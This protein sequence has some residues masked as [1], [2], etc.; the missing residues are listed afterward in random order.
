MKWSTRVAKA[1]KHRRGRFTRQEVALASTWTS[2]AIGELRQ[3][4]K[5]CKLPDDPEWLSEAD[6]LGMAFCLA[7]RSDDPVGAKAVLDQIK[8]MG[9]RT[10]ADL[11]RAWGIDVKPRRAAGRRD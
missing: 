2:C 9:K 11:K 1:L 3:A 7:V 4:R 8:L 10:C 5:E 6:K